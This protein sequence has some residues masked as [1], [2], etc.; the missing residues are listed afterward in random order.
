MQINIYEDVAV[1]SDGQVLVFGSRVM[2]GQRRLSRRMV[3]CRCRRI[4][5]IASFG[6]AMMTDTASFGARPITC[7]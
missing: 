4:A 7:Q 1:V 6:D 2:M 3:R 5:R